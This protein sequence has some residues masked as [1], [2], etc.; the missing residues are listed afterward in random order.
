MNFEDSPEE[1]AYRR[2]CVAFLD[3]HARKRPASHVRGYRR[4]EDRPG[5]VASARAFQLKKFAAGFAGITLSL[6]HI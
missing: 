6:I 1:A 4:G 3:A 5:V 2:K